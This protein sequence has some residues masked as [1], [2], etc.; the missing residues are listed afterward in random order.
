MTKK[1]SLI[2]HNLRGF[3]SHL[4]LKEIGRFH[5]KVNAIPNGIE[6]YM[7]FTV[8]NNLAFIDSMKFMNSSLDTLVKNLSEELSG[9]LLKLGKQ[10]GVYPKEYMDSFKKF[11]NEKLPD[12]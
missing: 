1:F 11:F 8:N 4:I 6:K 2:F 10:K 5:V 9:D 3:D 12:K 7:G